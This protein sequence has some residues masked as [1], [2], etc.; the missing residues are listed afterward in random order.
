MKAVYKLMVA[1]TCAFGLPV[2]C[3]PALAQDV[4][5]PA[6]SG[7][8]ALAAEFEPDPRVTL[9]MSGGPIDISNSIPECQ[10]YASSAPVV[11]LNYAANPG[12]AALPLFIH[13]FSKGDTMLLVNAP[14]GNWYCNDDGFNAQNPMLIFGPAMTGT[15]EIWLGS[16][17]P[18]EAHEAFLIFSEVGAA[19]EGLEAELGRK[20]GR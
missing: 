5:A 6:N 19:I 14:D 15:Y 16:F 8:V 4:S 12:P 18:G 20:D 10:G 11:R 2:L 7:N 9:V 13:A 3:Q 17:Q 1:L